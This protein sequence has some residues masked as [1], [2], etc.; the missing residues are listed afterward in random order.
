MRNLLIFFTKYNFVFLFIL[1]EI[2]SIYFLVEN[3]YYQK[4]TFINST[5][6]IASSI[7]DK[8]NNINNFFSLRVV[9]Q[10]LADENAKLH[11]EA[12]KSYMKTDTKIFIKDDTVY[13]QQYEY[14]SAKV[15][16]NTI[17]KRNNYLTLNKGSNSGIHPNMAVISPTGIV[18]IV[19][20][21][22]ENYA[23]VLSL[24]NKNFKIIA[25]T[26]KGN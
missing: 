19:K 15:I 13:R 18:G 11:S 14:V 2:I 23:S 8:V 7:Y 20:D 12:L 6:K 5:N 24:L 16:N 1:L 3:N 26:K 25:K 17:N 10:H 4:S 21:V 9:N 22:S